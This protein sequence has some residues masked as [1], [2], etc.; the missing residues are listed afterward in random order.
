TVRLFNVNDP[1]APVLVATDTTDA[2]GRY[3]FNVFDGLRT[4]N[5][6]VRET[7]PSGWALTSANPRN[8]NIPRGET[9]LDVDFGNVYVGTSA[10]AG[11]AA[12]LATGGAGATPT[13]TG[14]GATGADLAIASTPDAP[15]PSGPAAPYAGTSATPA[16]TLPPGAGSPVAAT[17]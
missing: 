1:A 2:N 16:S 17:P 13:A 8:V 7:V 10:P 11:A 15:A 4:G 3:R 14:G 6:Q 9:F 5:Y 12:P